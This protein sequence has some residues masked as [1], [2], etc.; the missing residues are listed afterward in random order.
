Q[1][2]VR[3][4]SRHGSR[5]GEND[6]AAGNA[7]LVRLRHAEGIYTLATSIT[8]YVRDHAFLQIE[9]TYLRTHYGVVL[10]NLGR[11]NEA[12]RRLNEASGYLS[13]SSKA[14]DG[15]AHAVIDLR[16]AETYL[17][18]AVAIIGE[19]A[20]G[21]RSGPRDVRDVARKVQVGEAYLDDMQFALERARARFVNHR[22]D[23]WWWTLMSELELSYWV[24][25][26][27]LRDASGSGI[28]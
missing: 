19:L 12:H 13:Q 20:V 5:G 23:V 2:S 21:E 14:T 7:A 11:F 17:L 3:G 22:K 24:H 28:A 16:R 27:R 1:R 4:R 9:N 18:Q 10:A 25:R 8:R 15:L 26:Q 6:K